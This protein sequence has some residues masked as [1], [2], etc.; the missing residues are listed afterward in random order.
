M[1]VVH[2]NIG[3]NIEPRRCHIEAA[4]EALRAGFNS[5]KV[6]VSS[7]VETPPWG[8][9]SSN[10]F[11]NCGVMIS[12][13]QPVDPFELLAFIQSIERKLG[14]G[15]AHRN[16]DGSYADRVL[17]IDI[18]AVDRLI[19][20]SPALILP[21]PRARLRAFVMAPLTQLDE[22]AARWIASNPGSPG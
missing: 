16:P 19:I 7:F 2:L 5:S 1:A 9:D 22:P 11:L 8:F 10:D 13:V 20:N 21:H 14:G 18:I 6:C 3:S 12:T 15:V 4:V 17:D